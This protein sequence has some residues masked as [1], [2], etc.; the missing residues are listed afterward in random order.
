MTDSLLES[1]NKMAAVKKFAGQNIRTSDGTIAYITKDG[2]AKGYTDMSVYD[3]TAG[4]NGCPLNSVQ[5]TEEWNTLGAPLGSVM[6]KGQSCGLERTYVTSDPPETNFDPFFYK[7]EYMDVASMTNEQAAAHW[8][9]TGKKEGRLPNGDIMKSMTALGQVGYIDFDTVARKVPASSIQYGNYKTYKQRSNISGADMADCTPSNAISYADRVVITNGALSGS[10]QSAVLKFGSSG[11]PFFVRPAPNSASKALHYGDSLSLAQSITTYSDACGYWGCNVS[12]VNTASMRLEFGPGGRSG[13]TQ[14]KLVAPTGYKDGDL[15]RYGA[16]FMMTAAVPSP[17]YALFQGKTLVPGKSL[18][19]ASSQYYVTFTT[20]GRM[21][22]YQH[23]NKE[24]FSSKVTD[25]NPR[26]LSLNGSGSLVATN[27]DGM[28]FWSTDTNGKGT[29]PYAFA[30][31]DDGRAVLYDSQ[32][33]VIWS[34]GTAS[35][36]AQVKMQTLYATVA[37][38][39]IVFAPVDAKTTFTFENPDTDGETHGCDVT[40]LKQQCGA[41]CL[42]FVHNPATNEWQQLKTTQTNAFSIAP[43]MQD[44][45]LKTPAVK[46]GDQLISVNDSGF[47]NSATFGSFVQGADLSAADMTETAMFMKDSGFKNSATFGSFVQGADLSAADMTET[48]MFMKDSGFVN[49]ATVGSFVQGGDLS[50]ADLSEADMTENGG[51]KMKDPMKEASASYAAELAKDYA[52]A[53]ETANKYQASDVSARIS[54]YASTGA[55]MQTKVDK[56][57]SSLQKIKKGVD[58]TTYERQR[59][60]SSVIDRQRKA[61][62]VIWA[63]AVAAVL[64]LI[65]VVLKKK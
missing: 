47:V 61:Q 57:K 36:P 14:L 12:F 56:Y 40:A 59:D 48:A 25:S 39:A 49:S 7:K 58:T 37:S 46:V 19:S 42:G 27:A 1:I 24:M 29:P 28:V 30:V 6:A 50:A 20:D 22:L 18:T 15:L 55:V 4:K 17:D 45:Y 41:D 43:T 3:G 8:D 26:T 52:K 65:V 63:V 31:Q 62:F 10:I 38:G 11:T 32:L 21:I 64:G 35:G 13:G 9:S 54:N 5:L 2:F 51:F 23:T 44:L 16:Q 33:A 34:T 60:D 53:Q